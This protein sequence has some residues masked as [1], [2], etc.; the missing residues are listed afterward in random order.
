MIKRDMI[1]RDMIK[2]DVIRHHQKRLIGEIIDWGLSLTKELF[3]F[4]FD[5][6]RN[7]LCIAVDLAALV[8]TLPIEFAKVAF[9]VATDFVA[10]HTYGCRLVN[11][12]N[13][14]MSGDR[15]E[16]IMTMER[17][18]CP[19]DAGERLKDPNLC[20][21]APGADI[22]CR[23]IMRKGGILTLFQPQVESKTCTE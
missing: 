7:G 18:A 3:T 10:D 22:V 4:A 1:K 9:K 13:I 5:L 16:V 2:R 11:V 15:Y 6:L 19:R 14:A 20:P 17:T 8:V 21:K 12:V 23:V